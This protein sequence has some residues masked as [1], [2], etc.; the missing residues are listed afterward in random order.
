MLLFQSKNETN[1]LKSTTTENKVNQIT[2]LTNKIKFAQ[3]KYASALS[4]HESIKTET[5]KRQERIKNIDTEIQNWK[6]LKF[7]SEK[8]SKE[9]HTR[10]NKIKIELEDISKLPETIAVKKGQLMQNISDTESKKQELSD[11][12]VNAE[13]EISKNK[14][15]IK[16]I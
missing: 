14:Q 6:N 4:K 8:M 5:I 3:E 12:L 11:E 15:R 9:L 10:I 7:N 2:K 13:E 1:K 16:G